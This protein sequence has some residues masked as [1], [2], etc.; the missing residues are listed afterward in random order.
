MVLKINF[1]GG[2]NPFPRC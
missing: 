1:R 2:K